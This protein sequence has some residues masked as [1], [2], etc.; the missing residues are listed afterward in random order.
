MQSKIT[1]ED[2]LKSFPKTFQEFIITIKNIILR[3]PILL[4]PSFEDCDP[5]ELDK[6]L[7]E[8]KIEKN[9]IY[10]K[11]IQKSIEKV[12]V[13]M[14]P[15]SCNPLLRLRGS[16]RNE[17]SADKRKNATVTS[18]DVSTDNSRSSSLNIITRTTAAAT[19]TTTSPS[20]LPSS[21]RLL[22]PSPTPTL[23]PTRTRTTIITT[24]TTTCTN[25]SSITSGINL[26]RPG[27]SLPSP[28]PLPLSPPSPTPTSSPMKTTTTTIITGENSSRPQSYFSN[29]LKSKNYSFEVVE[30]IIIQVNILCNYKI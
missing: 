26:I 18:G 4:D 15:N 23:P 9:K 14:L 24:T 5:S 27:I 20:P 30:N 25:S 6:I 16:N 11:E 28:L 2:F 29:I 19:T 10:L 3:Q 13:K 1:V 12:Q 22:S 17:K 21:L 7:R 8:N